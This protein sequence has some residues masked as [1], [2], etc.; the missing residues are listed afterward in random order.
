MPFASD[1]GPIMI[2]DGDSPDNPVTDSRNA[3]EK[4]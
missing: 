3:V 2:D 4:V 1:V